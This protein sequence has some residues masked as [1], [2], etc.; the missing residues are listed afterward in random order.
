MRRKIFRIAFTYAG[1]ENRQ[2]VMTAPRGCLTLAGTEDWFLANYCT[3][4]SLY[5][6]DPVREV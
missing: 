4:G 2:D 6:L 3:Q 1:R 5:S